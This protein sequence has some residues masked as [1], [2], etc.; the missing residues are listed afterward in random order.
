[1]Q[2]HAWQGWEWS[3]HLY[4]SSVHAAALQ[5][6]ITKVDPLSSRLALG[7]PLPTWHGGGAAA[8]SIALPAP[9]TKL[10]IYGQCF[11]AM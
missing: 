1:M 10:G 7:S 3:P 11:T 9:G 8:G 2:T 6:R 4:R 5:L